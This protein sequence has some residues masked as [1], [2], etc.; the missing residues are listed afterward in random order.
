MEHLADTKLRNRV[1]PPPNPTAEPIRLEDPFA[2]PA[3]LRK[4]LET[5]RPLLLKERFFESILR[6]PPIAEIVEELEAHLSACEIHAYHCTREPYPGF[7]EH[8]GLRLTDIKSH[9]AE[10]LVTHGHLFSTSQLSA[11]QRR[12]QAYFG[13]GG[14]AKSRNGRIWAC[15]SRSLLRDPGVEGFF[16]YYGGEAIYKPLLME[17]E[18]VAILASIGRPVVV[19]IAMAANQLKAYGP[20]AHTAISQ[21]HKSVRPDAWAY[22]S[23]ACCRV[24]IPPEKV[25]RVTPRTE[26]VV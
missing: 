8:H 15:L 9:Q 13:S 19:E 5:L 6:R 12:W 11:V 21:Y 14:Q 4:T 18:I 26:F 16:Q 22:T 3:H 10:F 7:F 25:I 1:M 2:L 23:E 20:L 24:P 17:P